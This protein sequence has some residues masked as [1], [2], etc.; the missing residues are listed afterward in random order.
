M[1]DRLSLLEDKVER[2][3]SIIES[4]QARL[5]ALERAGVALPA[6]QP[7]EASA[8]DDRSAPVERGPAVERPDLVGV[9]SL[10]GR[11]FIVLGGAFLLRAMTDNGTLPPAA[12]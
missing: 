4:L 6:A 9:L 11:L 5:G 3:S 1:T 10:L 2:L 7:S 8:L 12:G